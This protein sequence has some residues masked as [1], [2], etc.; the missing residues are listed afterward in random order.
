MNIILDTNSIDDYARFLRIKALPTYSFRGRLATVP[1]EYAGALSGNMTAIDS[2][3]YTPW[4]GMFD[5]QEGIARLAIR[6]RKFCVFARPGRGKTFIMGECVR[7]ATP[8]LAGKRSLIVS[9]LMVVG[10]TLAEFQKFYGDNL[11][12][13]QVRAAD[14]Q[15]FL[16]GE[17][18]HDIGITNFEAITD[19]I[20]PGLLG[21]LAI[22][23]SS[24]M[25]SHYGKWATKLIEMGRGLSWKF[26]FTGTPAPNDQ[27]EYGN[28][29]VFMDAFP[30]V[31]AFLAKFFV[32][33]GQ[34]QE[35]WVLRPHALRPFYRALSHWCIFLNDPATYGW[36]DHAG[37]LPPINVTIHDVELTDEQVALT[38][39]T[40]GQLLATNLGGIA[41]RASYGQIAKGNYKGREVDTLKPAFIR[42]LVDSWPDESTIIW[43][44][45]NEEQK[46]LARTF[47]DAVDIDGTTPIDK[48]L[49][50]IDA[51]KRGDKRTLISKSKILGF[52]L[53]L[54]VTTR[55]VFSG[56]QDSYES[57]FQCVCRANRV[58]STKP[59]NVHIPITDIERPMVDTVLRKAGRVERDIAEQE[60]IFKETGATWK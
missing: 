36:R 57:Y 10:Q 33:R 15:S 9:P 43:C 26:C 7:H 55:M 58:G 24:M 39:Q 22:D 31:N 41:T 12:V 18:E 29:A 59:L 56:L 2:G 53:N 47:P 1:D 52:G 23:E 21:C 46:R 14:L 44:I 25:K 13:R 8:R 3:D 32:N 38:M 17:G 48:R 4:P 42:S 30:N 54:Q 20:R 37:P 35:R 5:Y 50:G 16:D 34:T 11:R 49:E 45:Y 28:H 51:Y 19:D 27:I 60:A 40:S 6:K